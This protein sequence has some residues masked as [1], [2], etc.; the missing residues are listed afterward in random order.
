[1]RCS[2]EFVCGVSIMNRYCAFCARHKTDIFSKRHHRTIPFFS[3]WSLFVGAELHSLSLDNLQINCRS[4]YQTVQMY[5][6]EQCIDDMWRWNEPQTVTCIV[7]WVDMFHVR[8]YI[9]SSVAWMCAWS[10]ASWLW[11]VFIMN[12]NTQLH[13]HTVSALLQF[14]FRCRFMYFI[15]KSH[16]CWIGRN[17][18]VST[19]K[20]IVKRNHIKKKERNSS[21][22][23]KIQRN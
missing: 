7:V 10:R 13:T 8:F 15:H 21:K 14:N 1:M 6:V 4:K 16:L 5:A 11:N 17:C 20:L 2:A 19:S 18:N 23:F 22:L 12:N 9:L 3:F